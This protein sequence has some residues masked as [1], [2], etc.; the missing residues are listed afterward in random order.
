MFTRLF[1]NYFANPGISTIQHVPNET[2]YGRYGIISSA[3]TNRACSE[4]K[5]GTYELR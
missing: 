3:L 1:D 5:V 4:M 2:D